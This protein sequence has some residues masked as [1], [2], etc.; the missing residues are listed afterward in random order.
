M[1]G[2]STSGGDQT[3]TTTAP[4]AT[5]ATKGDRNGTTTDNA[6]ATAASPTRRASPG[7]AVVPRPVRTGATGPGVVRAGEMVGTVGQSG[8]TGSGVNS[9]R[10]WSMFGR[11]WRANRSHS[12]ACG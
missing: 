9:R 5:A 1:P 12:A 11:T 3:L 7:P 6:V 8:F 2:P 4:M 10:P